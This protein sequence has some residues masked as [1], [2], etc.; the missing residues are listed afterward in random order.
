MGGDFVGGSDVGVALHVCHVS[1]L[2]AR[3]LTAGTRLRPL[4]SAGDVATG[5]RGHGTHGEGW[6][7]RGSVPG[8]W[9]GAAGW[10][11]RANG[12]GGGRAAGGQ[13]RRGGGG[14]G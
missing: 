1:A 2:V 3:A 9:P 14:P 8:R 4:R 7:R 6:S 12:P 10:A 11:G 5:S 13:G